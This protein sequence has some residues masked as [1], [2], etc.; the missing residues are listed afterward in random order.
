MLQSADHLIQL[1]LDEDLDQRGDITTA[2]MIPPN[3][4][5][6]VRIV[7]R[8]PGVLAG[9][10]LIECVYQALAKRQRS[11]GESADVGSV[12]VEH[13]LP[14]GAEL[15]A[16][17]VA[18]KLSG[19]VRSLLSGERVV[20]NFLMHLSGVASL[21]AAFVQKVRD[22]GAVILD[23]RKTLPG[24]R[25]LQKYAVRC[26][27]G[28]NHRM[29]LF[30]GM[31]IKDNHLA[32]QSSRSPAEAVSVA[33]G[34]LNSAGLSVPVEIEV[35]TLDQLSDALSQRPEIVLLD[36]MSPTQLLKAVE[37][38]DRVAPETLLEA[39]GGVT[40]ETVGCIAGTGVERISI[41]A[42]THSARSLD[43]G[44]DWTT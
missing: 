15:K 43:L 25:L 11:D 33:R 31:L 34:Y 7:A 13:L 18:A 26:G 19:P 30:D 21:T 1:A 40:L 6:E 4:T 41:G 17:T 38:R 16:G 44:Y 10:V 9:G 12:C 22:S 37:L 24:Y 28:S 35:D 23:T 20:L 39:S 3:A 32:A 2:A 42:L 8:E 14:D 29:G 5:A 36:N 27:G